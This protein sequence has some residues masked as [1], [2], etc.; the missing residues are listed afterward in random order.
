VQQLT[1]WDDEFK[2][3][4][5]QEAENLLTSTFTSGVFFNSDFHFAM[6]NIMVPASENWYGEFFSSHARKLGFVMVTDNGN[7]VSRSAPREINKKANGRR[8]H[9]WIYIES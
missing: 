2:R 3:K 9:A 8:E 5:M 7:K 4:W 1:L 6:E